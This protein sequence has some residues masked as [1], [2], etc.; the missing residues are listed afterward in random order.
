MGICT[1]LSY[2]LN[3]ADE[4]PRETRRV[5]EDEGREVVA[6]VGGDGKTA[7]LPRLTREMATT[8]RLPSCRASLNCM[9]APLPAYNSNAMAVAPRL[10]ILILRVAKHPPCLI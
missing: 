10:G 1:G 5:R 9:G 3:G 2:R 6:T 7:V 4:H 8:P